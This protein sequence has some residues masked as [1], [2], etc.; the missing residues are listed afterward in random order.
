MTSQ[1]S[2][3]YFPLKAL[4]CYSGMSVFT[5]RKY[6]FHPVHPLSHYRWPGKI[7]VRRSEFDAWLQNFRVD[8]PS[9]VDDIVADVMNGL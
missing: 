1:T 5:L 7:V 9:H 8:E 3:E 2:D 6:L 4:A